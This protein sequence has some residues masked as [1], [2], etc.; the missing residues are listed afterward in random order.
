M[1]LRW[2]VIEGG[3]RGCGRLVE[4]FHALERALT[5][6][7]DLALCTLSLNDLW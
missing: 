5:I 6:R 1:S 4:G 3:C 2:P 7:D